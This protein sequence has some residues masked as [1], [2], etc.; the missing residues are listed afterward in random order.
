MR[1]RGAFVF[2]GASTLL[3]SCGDRKGHG[4]DLDLQRIHV[5]TVDRTGAPVAAVVRIVADAE[6]ESKGEHAGWHAQFIDDRELTTSA[7]G[8]G[9]FPA[10]RYLSEDK[11]WDGPVGISIR[12]TEIV[13]PEERRACE[14]SVFTGI[15]AKL[16]PA[17]P[18]DLDR[19]EGELVYVLGDE[20]KRLPAEIQFKFGETLSDLRGR[21]KTREGRCH[22]LPQ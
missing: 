2:V 6:R 8:E 22:S 4:Y 15:T 17:L 21:A 16:D 18:A 13:F 14:A 9:F 19:R 11:L 12:V 1:K 10:K 5:R 20:T 3:F 7:V